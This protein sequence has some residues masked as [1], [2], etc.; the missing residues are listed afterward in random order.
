MPIIRVEVTIDDQFY[1]AVEV[2]LDEEDA[3]VYAASAINAVM[4]EIGGEEVEEDKY[5]EGEGDEDDEP[6]PSGIF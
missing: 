5:D 2:E 3:D 4:E 1:S 6:S